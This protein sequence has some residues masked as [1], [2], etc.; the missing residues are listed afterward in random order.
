MSFLAI[1]LPVSALDLEITVG[2]FGVPAGFPSPADDDLEDEINLLEWMVPHPG[3]TFLFRIDGWCLKD[4]GIMDRDV[5]AVD[6]AG[7]AR[8]GRAVMAIVDG[9]RMA[10]VIRKSRGRV[11]LETAN[12]AMGHQV[13]PMSG[14]V[15]I[16]GVIA[17]VVRRYPVE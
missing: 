7:T 11:W 13:V 12:A 14:T 6:R 9:Q 15:E 10:K 4:L 5:V 17:G 2:A 8:N 16:F 1:D 3:A